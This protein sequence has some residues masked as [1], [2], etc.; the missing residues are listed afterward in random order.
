MSLFKDSQIREG[1]VLQFRVE[2][3]NTLNHTNFDLPDLF[4]GSPTFGHILSAQGPRRIQFGFKL[5]F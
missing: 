5:I 2:F 3:F 1:M 4:L